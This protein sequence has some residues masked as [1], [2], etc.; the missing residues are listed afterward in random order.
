MKDW[1]SRLQASA[2]MHAIGQ[3]TFRTLC[4]H[5]DSLLLLHHTINMLFMRKKWAQ[6]T[7]PIASGSGQRSESHRVNIDLDTKALSLHIKNLWHLIIQ[8]ADKN[9]LRHLSNGGT[10][11]LV[12]VLATISQVLTYESLP[13]G[14]VSLLTNIYHQAATLLSSQRQYFHVAEKSLLFKETK[15]GTFRALTKD[16]TCRSTSID[17]FSPNISKE[18]SPDIDAISQTDNETQHVDPMV[19]EVSCASQPDSEA[20]SWLLEDFICDTPNTVSDVQNES[21]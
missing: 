12:P 8:L 19:L 11:A 1:H 4:F 10:W 5:W 6:S 16:S 18:P 21:F 2:S 9:Q 14:Q 13:S 3:S 7:R 15:E 20:E 17:N